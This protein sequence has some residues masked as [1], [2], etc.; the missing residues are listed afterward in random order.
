VLD[1]HVEPELLVDAATVPDLTPD[2][3][4]IALRSGADR[5]NYAAALGGALQK[6]GVVVGP[7]DTAGHSGTIFAL[8]ALTGLLSLMLVVVAGLAVLNTVVLDTRDRVHDIGVYKALGMTPRQVVG[9]TVGSVVMTG[10]VGGLVGVPAGYALHAGIMRM[11]GNAAGL[12][13][14]VQAVHVYRPAELGALVIGGLLI[15]VSGALVPAGWAARTQ[16]VTALRTE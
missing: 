1:P 11:M 13:L 15:A 5:E 12:H 3:Y 7:N 9:M 8:H 6:Y 2:S 10:L 16:T 14:P 4:F